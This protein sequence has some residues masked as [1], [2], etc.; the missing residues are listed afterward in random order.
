MG[1]QRPE[2][3]GVR[4]EINSESGQ[5]RALEVGLNFPNNPGFSDALETSCVLVRNKG[6]GQIRMVFPKEKGIDHVITHFGSV[7][8]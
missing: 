7:G 1:I 3:K 6:R 5:I 8:G 2:L 4:M